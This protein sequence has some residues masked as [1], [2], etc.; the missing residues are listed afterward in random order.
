MNNDKH[1]ALLCA[2]RALVKSLL[3]KES[4]SMDVL[5]ACL[6]TE[7]SVLQRQGLDGASQMLG[8]IAAQLPGYDS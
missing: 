7:Q 5:I 2:Y 1:V 8:E 4:I 3:A 6:A